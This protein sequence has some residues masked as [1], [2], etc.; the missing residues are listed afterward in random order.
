MPPVAGAVMPTLVAG[1]AAGGVPHRE[2]EQAGD[3]Q[4]DRKQQRSERG[5]D[6]TNRE[7]RQL[8]RDRQ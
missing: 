4:V 1:P 7:Y 3:E 8:R 2:S 5:G 6:M